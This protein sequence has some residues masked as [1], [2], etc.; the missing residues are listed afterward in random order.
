MDELSTPSPKRV[1][2]VEDEVLVAENLRDILCG[3]GYEVSN[4]CVT[5]EEALQEVG[6]NPL[7]LLLM[8]IR[9]KGKLDGVETVIRAEQMA[10]KQFSVIFLTAHSQR[11][12]PHIS[13]VKSRFTYLTKPYTS[14]VLVET[15]KHL[16]N[17]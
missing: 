3:E 5:G 13:D 1:L 14:R 15:V 16:L 17:E 10:R 7:D 12:F 9:L 2:V 6:R 4:I 8:D 11:Q